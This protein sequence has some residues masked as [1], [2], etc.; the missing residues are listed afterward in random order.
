MMEN[1][2]TS[3]AAAFEILLEEIEAEID[4]VNR[5]GARAFEERD[6][7]KGKRSYRAGGTAHRFPL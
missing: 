7:E 5:A 1:H 6:Y 2:P 3:V 4:F